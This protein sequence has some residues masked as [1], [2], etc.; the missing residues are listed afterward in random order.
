MGCV[1]AISIM[2]AL[3]PG[4]ASHVVDHLTVADKRATTAHRDA[5]L[6]LTLGDTPSGHAAHQLSVPAS[7][8]PQANSIVDARILH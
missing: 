8:Y 7:K 6:S 2:I 4:Y 1:I 3:V 5:A